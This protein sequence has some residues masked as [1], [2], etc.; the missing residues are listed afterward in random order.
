MS[1]FQEKNL[2]VRS[3]IW[4]E[5][6]GKPF[7]GQGRVDLLLAIDRRGSVIEASRELNIP[8]RRVRGVIREMEDGIGQKMVITKRGGEEGG[9]AYI[10]DLARELLHCFVSLQEGI[11]ESV[12]GNFQRSFGRFFDTDGQL[13]P[14]GISSLRTASI[15]EDDIE[16][17]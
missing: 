10:T 6:K 3:K 5:L 2:V 12:D 11:R 4:L 14:I 13:L 17:V 8:Y 9:S 16:T 7:L 1:N 15:E